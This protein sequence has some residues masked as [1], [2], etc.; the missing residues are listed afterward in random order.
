M[1]DFGNYLFSLA[2]GRPR[3]RK[4]LAVWPLV[5]RRCAPAEVGG[6]AGALRDGSCSASLL[7]APGRLPAWLIRNRTSRALFAGAGEV[8]STEAQSAALIHSV[9]VDPGA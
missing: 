1:Y 5:S 9:V 7:R 4:N 6:L 8:L 3:S 2:I